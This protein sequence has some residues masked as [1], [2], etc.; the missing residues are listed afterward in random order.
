VEIL[1]A[2]EFAERR[3]HLHVYQLP[4]HPD[5]H[6]R[7]ALGQPRRGEREADDHGD[8]GDDEE[9]P[10]ERRQRP[11]HHLILAPPSSIGNNDRPSSERVPR[12]A[13]AAERAAESMCTMVLRASVDPDGRDLR[14]GR[15]RRLGRDLR[16]G[17]DR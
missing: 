4:V 9:R 15:D 5:A 12:D 6:Q 10:P 14:L 17:R 7:W 1:P 13:W 11:P 3:P 8:G 2:D 16:L